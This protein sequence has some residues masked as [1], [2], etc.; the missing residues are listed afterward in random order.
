L[1]REK[2]LAAMNRDS[3]IRQAFL[4]YQAAIDLLLEEHRRLSETLMQSD[5]SAQLDAP[6]TRGPGEEAPVVNGKGG[7]LLEFEAMDPPNLTFTKVV[8]ASFNGSAIKPANWKQLLDA[9]L[10]HA[11]KKID[12][13]NGLKRLAA[14]NIVKGRKADEGYHYLPEADLSVQG[15]DANAAWRGVMSIAQNLKCPVDVSFMWRSKEGAEHP[16]KAGSMSF[17]G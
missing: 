5:Q 12:D 7:R 17:F 16:G 10:I 2:E 4:N 14:V 13:F 1:N 9:A 6:E 15:Q 8:I 3:E 11:A